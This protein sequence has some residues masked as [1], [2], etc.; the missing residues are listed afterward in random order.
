MKAASRGRADERLELDLMIKQ[1]HLYGPGRRLHPGPEE[2]GAFVPQRQAAPHPPPSPYA[3]TE[4]R[5]LCLT[6]LGEG[7]AWA[8]I[9]G[10]V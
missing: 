9:S 3:P 10:K 7:G 1:L 8:P 5:G 6:P 2:R 4:D